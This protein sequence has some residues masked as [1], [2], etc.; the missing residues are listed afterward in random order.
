MS[1]EALRETLSALPYT[2]SDQILSFATFIEDAADDLF[3][4]AGLPDPTSDQINQLV[5]IAGIWRLW[6]IVSGQLSLLNAALG[7]LSE[8]DAPG[9]ADRVARPSGGFLLGATTYDRESP[10]YHLLLEL[11]TNLRQVLRDQDLMYVATSYTIEPVSASSG[12]TP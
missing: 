12:S 10:T 8:T 9:V 7:F 6:K 3:P 11:E 4:A 2:L 1:L 5:Y